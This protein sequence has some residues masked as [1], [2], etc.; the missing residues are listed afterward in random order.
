[1]V[2]RNVGPPRLDVISEKLGPLGIESDRPLSGLSILQRR[3]RLR[4]MIEFDV[5]LLF[6]KVV[7]VQCA[8]RAD[9]D[10]C[11]PQERKQHVPGTG[12]LELVEIFED[13]TCPVCREHFISAVVTPL[14]DPDVFVKLRWHG[15]VVLHP[16]EE[17]P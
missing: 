14:G 16:L 17:D 11:M 6:V 5:S 4:S 1:M 15:S 2:I 9:P 10:S 12:V 3:A 13:G 7:N 8:S